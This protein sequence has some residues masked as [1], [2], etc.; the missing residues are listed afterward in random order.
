MR[1]DFHQGKEE[2]TLLP[3]DPDRIFLNDTIIMTVNKSSPT[4]VFIYN[5]CEP[6]DW[7]T[8]APILYIYIIITSYPKHKF[9]NAINNSLFIHLVFI[10]NTVLF[11]E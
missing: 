1:H 10:L 4:F 3:N 2:R 9:K 8:K 7:K 11:V 5:V 6:L